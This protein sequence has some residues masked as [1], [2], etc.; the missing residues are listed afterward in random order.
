[1][2]AVETPPGGGTQAHHAG[3]AQPHGG[4]LTGCLQTRHRGQKEGGGV[5]E[6]YRRARA[7]PPSCRTTQKGLES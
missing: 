6:E 7:P 1:M 4:T 3:P 2:N 5:A